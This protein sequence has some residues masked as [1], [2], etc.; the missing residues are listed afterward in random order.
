M[1]IV[2]EKRPVEATLR[3]IHACAE[4]MVSIETLRHVCQTAWW[5][6]ETSLRS[7]RKESDLSDCP[8]KSGDYNE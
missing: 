2:K 6:E 7:R 1:S 8:D 4:D 5:T 3:W